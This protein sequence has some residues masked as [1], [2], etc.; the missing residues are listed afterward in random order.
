MSMDLFKKAI[1]EFDSF[2]G[3]GVTLTPQV[4]EPLIDPDFIEKIKYAKSKT[5]VSSIFFNTNGILI[6]QVGARRIITS[7][8]DWIVISIS[9]FDAQTYLRIYRVDHWNEVYEGILNLLREN[10]LCGNRVKIIIGL[11]S[12]IP[13]WELLKAPAYKKIKKYRFDLD[14]NI[15]Y[16]NWSG[17]IKREALRG[18]M[19]LRDCPQKKEPCAVLYCG[20]TIFSN[21]DMT[22]CGCRDLNG[23]SEL[24]LGNI[25]ERSILEM[26]CDG[27][28]KGIR[29]N[30]YLSR[31]P[32]LCQRC[33]FYNDLTCFRQQKI[34]KILKIK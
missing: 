15:H 33:S 17:L 18:A 31:Y 6:N 2:G 21:G 23:D 4:G 19:R 1:D 16:D 11:R 27:R 29:K 9:G 30:F 5:N 7:G 10:E 20:P 25:K 22:I 12:D 34:K 28:A 3:G 8:V 32:A 24:V 26:W 14:Y 13:I